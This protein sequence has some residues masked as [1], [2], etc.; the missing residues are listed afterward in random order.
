MKVGDFIGIPYKHL[1]RD[2][3]GLDCWGLV[4]LFYKKIKNI[5]LPD[6]TEYIRDWHD[7]GENTLQEQL[8]TF[9]GLWDKVDSINK[10]DIV[11]FKDKNSG[12]ERHC[13]VYL[14]DDKILHCYHGMSVVI[15]RLSK[16][17]GVSK[18]VRYNG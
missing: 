16:W 2:E 5:E 6:Y 10:H 15:D 4:L 9:A 18:I 17:K 12:I 8:D 13:A 11:I 7:A 1:G 14:G 3:S